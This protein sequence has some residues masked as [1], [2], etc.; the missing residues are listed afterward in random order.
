MKKSGI[1]GLILDWAG[2]TVDY[3]CIAPTRVFIE[4]FRDLGIEVTMS[5]ARGPM[6][7]A[8]WVHVAEILKM[9]NIRKQWTKVFQKEPEKAD[10]DLVYSKVEPKMIEIVNDYGTL[11]KGTLEL[12]EYASERE[13]KIGSTT[14]YVRPIMDRLIPFA[15]KQGYRPDSVVTPSEVPAGRPF[16]WMVYQ[17]AMNM[18]SFPLSKMVK[19]GDT[20][21]DI[22]E[23]INAGMWVVAVI[24]SGNE[25]GFS[26]MEI[27]EQ[28]LAEIIKKHNLSER[29]FKKAGAH[30]IV[31]GIWDCLPVLDEISDKIL[32]G[33][34]PVK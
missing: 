20:I 34:S 29:K 11:I 23:G 32:K 31:N 15:A 25:M 8:K 14:G 4:V 19:I 21:A 26:E 28:N 12:A 1:K 5:E 22:E 24:R 6:G 10:I 30:Y 13:I 27:H 17:N 18:G 16:P 9:E 2:T 3:G 33:N 7:L